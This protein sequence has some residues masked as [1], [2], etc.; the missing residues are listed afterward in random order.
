MSR[1]SK[2]RERL[3]RR[4]VHQSRQAARSKSTS[5][6]AGFLSATP[7]ERRQEAEYRAHH[8]GKDTAVHEAGHA[9]AAWLQGVKIVRMMFNDRGSVYYDAAADHLEAMTATGEAITADEIK[10]LQGTAEGF[11]R[12][13]QA[14]FIT[15][16][17]AM[18]QALYL[19][20]GDSPITMREHGGQAAK[21]LQ[22][23]SGLSEDAVI[24]ERN[25]LIPVVS[26]ALQDERIK[27]V[28]LVLG[29]AFY[30]KR[31]LSGE[32]VT[33]IIEAAWSQ[34]ERRNDHQ[35]MQPQA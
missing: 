7:E 2:E 22:F 8:N 32:S 3:Q 1:A 18:A 24:A 20:K 26:N 4:A 21:M 12:G 31:Y 13:C 27:Y 16:A 29:R 14:A 6:H 35:G 17:G 5:V 28:T 11:I 9:V 30:E 15:L 25:R 34:A 23:Y 19:N 10:D 33:S